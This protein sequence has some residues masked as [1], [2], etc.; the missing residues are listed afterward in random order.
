MII[1]MDPVMKIWMYENWIADQNDKVEL[2]KNHAYL[3][4]S[5]SNP[6]AVRNILEGDT[7]VS[8]DDEFEE[9]SKMVREI[10]NKL[11]NKSKKRKRKLKA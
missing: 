9:S 7:F 2:A 8:T 4:A 6:E 1:E 5:F 11:E 10:N 3:L